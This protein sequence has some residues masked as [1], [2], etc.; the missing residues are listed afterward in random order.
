MN[1]LFMVL[2]FLCLLT[3]GCG[4]DGAKKIA[5]NPFDAGTDGSVDYSAGLTGTWEGPYSDI[6]TEGELS[7]Q[8]SPAKASFS[9]LEGSSDPAFEIVLDTAEVKV[10]GTYVQV[11]SEFLLLKITESNLSSIGLPGSTVKISFKLMGK[12]LELSNTNFTML[13]LRTS[14]PKPDPKD[15]DAAD[16]D[17]SKNPDGSW[18]CFDKNNNKWDLEIAEATFTADIITPKDQVIRL[19]GYKGAA[20]NDLYHNTLTV[21]DSSHKVNIGS[22]LDIIVQGDNLK[23]LLSTKQQST[24][25]FTCDP[26]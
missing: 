6:D 12:A 26:K 5:D 18:L 22:T 13:V 4:E 17:Q 25:E 1:K 2:S 3:S 20:S 15:D 16:E 14:T 10:A 23:V 11:N 21:S 19:S 8:D 9:K 7:L 24:S